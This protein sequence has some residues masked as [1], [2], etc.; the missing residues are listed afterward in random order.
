[1]STIAAPRKSTDDMLKEREEVRGS[2]VE[3]LRLIVQSQRVLADL[4][5]NQARLEELLR[6]LDKEFKERE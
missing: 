1:M 5:E 4:Q 2:I 3:S 6:L